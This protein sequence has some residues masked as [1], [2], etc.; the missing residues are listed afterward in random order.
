MTNNVIVYDSGNGLWKAKTA[1]REIAIRHALLE[2]SETEYSKVMKDSRGV[3][4]QGY[5]RVNGTPYAFGEVAE[6][7]GA[8]KRSGAARYTKE[9]YGVSLAVM[10]SLVYDADNAG[11]D[12]QA[13]CSY[14]P[15]DS[16]Y[17]EHVIDAALGEYEIEVG[18]RRNYFNLEAATSFAEPVGGLMNVMLR[19]DGRGAQTDLLGGDT[20][21]IDIGEFTTD[22]VSVDQDG[23]IDQV[24]NTSERIGIREVTNNFEETLRNTY[25]DV[26]KTSAE[27][28]PH[29]IRKAIRT[30]IFE[31]G[32][33]EYPCSEIAQNAAGNVLNQI[34]NT[35]QNVAGGPARW[36]SI[37]LTG[38]GSA[39]LYTRLLDDYLEHGRVYI[40]DQDLEA[41][42]LANVR[43]GLKLWRFYESVGAND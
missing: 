20:L 35:Y 38:G 3:P 25:K 41:V 34:S 1:G 14:A 2:L 43:G 30:G 9:Y 21:V 28:P 16:D 11:G 22:F 15:R 4:P 5:I 6:K 12:V 36:D 33:R 24:L 13:F 26:L 27:I 18:K 7:R 29:R 31:A 17:E 19:Q 37:V 32:G 40:A 10:L 23:V 42:Y 8:K 39:M